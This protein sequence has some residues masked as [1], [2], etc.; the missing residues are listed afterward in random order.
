MIRTTSNIGIPFNSLSS[1]WNPL[2]PLGG[3]TPSFWIKENS[4][5]GLTLT[6][7]VNAANSPTILPRHLK[8]DVTAGNV[9]YYVADNGGLDI[10]GQDYTIFFK[11]K[12]DSTSKAAQK[13]LVCKGSGNNYYNIAYK[14]TTGYITVNYQTNEGT[15]YSIDSTVDFTAAGWVTVRFSVDYTNKIA[16]L[17]VN[18]IEAGAGTSFAG[19]TF[20]ANPV[21]EKFNINSRDD[22]TAIPAQT[23]MADVM[24]FHRIWT[25]QEAISAESGIY[26]SDAHEHWP[27]LGGNINYEYGV[28]GRFNLTASTVTAANSVG[29]SSYGS[30]YCLDYGWSLWRKF[31][32]GAL[33]TLEIVPYGADT[34]ALAALGFSLVKTYDG[35]L[36]NHNLAPSKI[37]FIEATWDRSDTNIWNALARGSDYDST[38]ANTKKQWLIEK[39]NQDILNDWLV[40]AKKDVVFVKVLT[41]SINTR[42]TL[43]EMFSYATAKTGSNLTKALTYT[44][45]TKDDF[46]EYYFTSLGATQHYCATRGN[47]VLA[48]DD[49]GTLYLSLDGGTTFP[50]SKSIQADC[51]YIE[52]AHIW[53]N[54]N[55]T[56]CG[57]RKV[58][59]S[60]DNLATYS[61]ITVYDRAGDL[62][63]PAT[64][65][66]FSNAGYQFINIGGRE[67]LVWGTISMIVGVMYDC[68]VWHSNDNGLTLHSIYKTNVDLP[69]IE[70]ERHFHSVNLNTVDNSLWLCT[71]DGEDTLINCHRIKGSY[72]AALL[73]NGSWDSWTAIL[74]GG[75]ASYAFC[76][77]LVFYNGY[78]YWTSCS[79]NATYKGVWRVPIADVADDTKYVRLLPSSAT[80]IVHLADGGNGKMM[81]IPY[82]AT[83][84]EIIISR[85]GI[86]F[87][88]RKLIGGP[89]FVSG[90]YLRWQQP[91]NGGYWLLGILEDGE[92]QSPVTYHA[93]ICAMVKFDK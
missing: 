2:K 10:A 19:K 12:T 76:S 13:T 61:Q 20:V 42:T 49:V 29:Y 43:K 82:P 68:N 81:A 75:I 45:D 21:G 60:T 55:I 1:Y 93:K 26:P 65:G 92:T 14:I 15:N 64:D 90:G 66:N 30:R 80:E 16:H 31:N 67:H 88:T 41:D 24:V 27:M 48:F 33:T 87:E 8:K 84:K 35:N 37:Q 17:Y 52:F 40:A 25:P 47:K 71:G 70:P 9:R 34:T 36:T 22:G 91:N 83:D 32:D 6:D 46:L 85:N 54:G 51:T 69:A 74:S 7:S 72:N 39:L 38:D 18:N 89:D 23:S 79:D 56:F 62:F 78:M 53:E 28:K 63:T 5:S 3:E 77:G 59:I 44:G 58:F 86:D 73:T 50:I 4:R 11:A 57:H